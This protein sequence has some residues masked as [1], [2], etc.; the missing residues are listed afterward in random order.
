M[1]PVRLTISAFGPYAGKEVIDFS[2][3]EGGLYLITGDT[4]AGKTTVFDAIMFALYGETSGQSRSATMLRS[5]FAAAD[6]PTFVELA[7]SYRNDGYTVLRKPEYRRKRKRGTGVTKQKKEAQL[8]GPDGLLVT[9][10][11]QVTEAIQD[12][13]QLSSGQFKQVVMIAQGEF[14]DLLE[15][16][17]EKRGDILRH[18]FSTDLYRAFQ[19]ELK[20][21]CGIMREERG[22]LRQQLEQVLQ[23]IQC[24]DDYSGKT[25]LM[26][27]VEQGSAQLQQTL[28]RLDEL[29]Q[30]DA[31]DQKAVR[32]QIQQE[33]EGLL[34]LQ[35]QKTRGEMTNQRLI[36]REAVRQEW[37][38]LEQE[39]TKYEA[40]ACKVSLS[41]QAL[42]QVRPAEVELERM[43]KTVQALTMEINRR[44]AD[45]R[46]WEP[47]W[48]RLQQACMDWKKQEPQQ[49]EWEQEKR[50][51]TAEL[52]QYQILATLERGCKNLRAK[53]NAA[54]IEIKERNQQVWQQ[55]EELQALDL[56]LER[57]R[58]AEVELER[59][60]GLRDAAENTMQRGE[61]L[62]ENQAALVKSELQLTEAEQQYLVEESSWKAMRNQAADAQAVFL[63]DQAG[64][65][66]QTMQPGMPCPVC[67]SCSHPAPAKR[68]E[69]SLSEEAIKE[70]QEAAERQ[71]KR[72]T[73]LANQL[74]EQRGKVGAERKRFQAEAEELLGYQSSED[75][76]QKE[77]ADACQACRI[78]L[79]RLKEQYQT[80]K[81]RCEKKAAATIKEKTGREGLEKLES[82]LAAQKEERER[83]QSMLQGK[84][85]VRT[86]TADEL[87]YGSGR[88]A[89]AEIQRLSCAL[90]QSKTAMAQ[91]QAE[92]EMQQ[93][94]VQE[95][96]AIL[97]TRREELPVAEQACTV[98]EA[99]L[100]QALMEA[101]FADIAAYRQSL[102]VEGKAVDE[103]WLEQQRKTISAYHSRRQA[104][105]RLF[106]QME[107]ELKGVASQEIAPLE[108][109]IAKKNRELEE[110]EEQ[111][112]GCY[113]R[114]QTN[115]V[116]ARRG[117]SGDQKLRDAERQY[118]QL[119][120]LSDTANGEL[121]GRV[122]ITFERYVQGTVFRQIIARANRR[123]YQ[124]TGSR[125]QLAQQEEAENNR[126]KTGLELDVIDHYTG[127]R[128]SVKTLSGGEAFQASL[129]L[130]LGLSDVVQSRSGGVKLDAMFIDEGFGSL[131]EEA[132]EQAMR[133]L[134]HLSGGSRLVG[135]ISHVSELKEAIERKIVVQSSEQGSHI[136][137]QV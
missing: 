63:C 119:K 30:F 64:V 22:D 81:K 46:K 14:R 108:E 23:T 25:V 130:A 1:R 134:R 116:V 105:E 27:G 73:T 52:R 60:S 80:L 56:L 2:K 42:Y 24:P 113:S 45:H 83:I 120:E 8:E 125:Y 6:T 82:K 10:D 93:K 33:K 109:Q 95:N 94:K 26:E 15:S 110:L 58:T 3:I 111:E 53:L 13:L 106:T 61:S 114:L 11:R 87:T 126:S 127:K 104:A 79:K 21:L 18:L 51:L 135:I 49:Q 75:A 91:T 137:I 19:E 77:L 76:L 122:K 74:A 96:Q 112:R 55:K 5:D 117:K 54:D 132:L 48:N 12:L 92:M 84:E 41:A 72:C 67:G 101:K 36:Q 37:E 66:A 39:R 118:L 38:A 71:Y 131:D 102:E 89:E 129:S 9:G 115:Q 123:L 7:F 31:V 78:E 43:R 17:S 28:E 65:M 99:Q 40:L 29:I 121:N 34:Q 133:M 47:E 32:Q 136:E 62:L 86:R 70:L 59:C 98:A 124:M 103:Q 88:E 57:W 90:E 44:E 85:A 4:G 35:E 97:Q 100:Q 69:K 50:R 128:R 20:R 68:T 16:D 107:Q